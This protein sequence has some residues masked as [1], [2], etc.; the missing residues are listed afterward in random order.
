MQV[1]IWTRATLPCHFLVAVW[2]DDYVA[3]V[4]ISSMV[5]LLLQSWAEEA[6]VWPFLLCFLALVRVS[7][8]KLMLQPSPWQTIHMMQ[9][10][11]SLQAATAIPG[12]LPWLRTDVGRL[13]RRP[14]RTY[15]LFLLCELHGQVWV[16]KLLVCE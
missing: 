13:H 7:A 16:L 3:Q 5:P 1:A 11:F 6:G 12:N 10:S 14:S 9:M 15:L 4:S 8:Q 2:F